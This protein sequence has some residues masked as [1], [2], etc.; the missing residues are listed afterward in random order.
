MT[1]STG[2]RPLPGDLDRPPEDLDLTDPPVGERRRAAVLVSSVL[3][4]PVLALLAVLVTAPDPKPVPRPSAVA[5]PAPVVTSAPGAPVPPTPPL[6]VGVGPVDATGIPGRVLEAYRVA[7]RVLGEP[8]PGCHLPWSLV[9]AIGRVESDHAGGGVVT[10]EG[11]T[12]S[13]IRGPRLD[14]TAGHPFFPDTDAGSLDGDPGVDLAVGPMQ[15]LPSSWAT[16]GAGDADD[17]DDAA[18]ASGRHLCAGGVDLADPAQR[19]AAVFGYNHSD[20]Y[21][22]QVL[23]LEVAYAAGTSAPVTL[24]SVP[25]DVPPDRPLDVAPTVPLDVAPA[26]PAVAPE[27][28][29]VPRPTHPVPPVTTPRPATT[30]MPPPVGTTAPPTTT[31]SA[32]T[33]SVTSTTPPSPEATPVA[34]PE[35]PLF[36]AS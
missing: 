1:T 13:P 14:G 36:P 34:E 12:L 27:L 22:A 23:A 28:A 26:V 4:V 17:V 20:A 16:Y 33:P 24:P 3:A 35:T 5:A 30:P 6:L 31:P 2:W 7:E 11:R 19:A 9:A 18:V 25:V 8:A 15:F 21:V 32:P 29:A 10:V